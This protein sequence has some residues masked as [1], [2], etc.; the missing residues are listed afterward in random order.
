MVSLHQKTSRLL[1][2]CVL[3]VPCGSGYRWFDA[4]GEV[5]LYEFG[6]GKSYAEFSWSDLS[7]TAD[8]VSC[9]VKNI[10]SRTGSVVAQLYLVRVCN[11]PVARPIASAPGSLNPFPWPILVATLSGVSHIG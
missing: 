1:Y 11:Y 4:T 8:S 5:P 10:A 2:L 7:A 3:L 9:N 6:A